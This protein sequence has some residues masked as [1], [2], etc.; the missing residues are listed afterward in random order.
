MLDQYS[1]I[2]NSVPKTSLCSKENTFNTFGY[3]DLQG[4]KYKKNRTHNSVGLWHLQFY[5]SPRCRFPWT[6]FVHGSDPV[7]CGFRSLWAAWTFPGRKQ[8]AVSNCFT[9]RAMQLVPMRCT[10]TEFGPKVSLHCHDSPCSC[11]F[12]HAICSLLLQCGHLVHTA[13]TAPLA[14]AISNY[15]RIH[16]QART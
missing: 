16:T 2:G 1:V 8:P 5:T 3:L 6:P 4:A 9:Q 10:L 15:L 12:H 11:E 7:H 14:V 13:H